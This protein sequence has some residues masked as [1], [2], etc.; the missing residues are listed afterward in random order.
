MKNTPCSATDFINTL[1]EKRV[2]APSR[3][4]DVRRGGDDDNNRIPKGAQNSGAPMVGGR[5]GAVEDASAAGVWSSWGKTLVS[6][7]STVVTADPFPATATA[8]DEETANGD[9]DAYHS[10][11]YQSICL[12]THC[13][14]VHRVNVLLI[15]GVIPVLCVLLGYIIYMFE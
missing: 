8:A 1:E 2:T 14:E 13:A 15:N 6:Q 4:G 5:V 10:Q 12:H 3:S 7:M 9:K 11:L